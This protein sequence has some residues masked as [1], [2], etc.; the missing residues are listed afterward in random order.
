MDIL[1]TLPLCPQIRRPVCVCG[2]CVCPASVI[3]HKLCVPELLS[4]FGTDFSFIAKS[5]YLR[6]SKDLGSVTCY[7]GKCKSTLKA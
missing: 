1:V 5:K 7:E 3:Y 4:L 2:V 6:I